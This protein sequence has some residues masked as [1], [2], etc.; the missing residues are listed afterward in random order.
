MEFKGNIEK[1]TI[2]NRFY[3][4]VV[5]TTK[6][7]QLVLMNL[8]PGQDIG[9]EIHSST[10]QFIRVEEGTG[11]AII[12]SKTYN[13]KDGDAVVIPSGKRHNIIAGRNG[14]KLY[15][16]YSPAEHSPNTIEKV[17]KV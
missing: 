9:A 11:R 4:K 7:S 15:T 1:L 5:N 6:Q 10:T 14:L 8:S 3:R 2:N 17:K 16:I 12:G 13:L